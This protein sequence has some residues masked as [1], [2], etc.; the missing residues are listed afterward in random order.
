M[1]RL[2]TVSSLLSPFITVQT[3]CHGKLL[4]GFLHCMGGVPL[5]CIKSSETFVY[6]F[7]AWQRDDCTEELFDC[8]IGRTL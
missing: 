6:N 2:S 7:K 5:H 8:C 3:T 4:F 1:V